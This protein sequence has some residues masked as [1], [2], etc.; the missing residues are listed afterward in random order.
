MPR[1]RIRRYLKRRLGA[2]NAIGCAMILPNRALA[3]PFSG[4]VF[5]D[6][7][8]QACMALGIVGS[9]LGAPAVPAVAQTYVP[10]VYESGLDNTAPDL[11]LPMRLSQRQLPY[12]AQLGAFW[13]YPS[14]QLDESLNDNI[15][16]T[17]TGARGDAI[18]TLSARTSLN[19]AAGINALDVQGWLADHLYA[20]HPTEDAW[21]GT[22][23]A[24]FTSDVHDDV[25]LVANG[26]IKRLVDPRTDPSGLQGLTPTTYEVYDGTAGT[27]IGHAETNLLDLRIGADRTTWDPLQGSLGPIITNDRDNTEIF[28]EAD[29]R[30][31]LAPGRDLYIKLRPNT[32]DYDLTFD[33]S[34]FQR[35]SNGVRADA[36]VDWN[37]DAALLL[38]V[39]GG[40]QRQAYNDPRFGTIGVPDARIK[41]SWWPTRLTNVT[42]NGTHE[43]YEAFFIPSPGAVRNKAVVRIDHE[44][45][46]R[47]LA[48][49][50]LSVER[51][52]LQ[53]TPTRYLAENAELSLQYLFADGFSAGIDYSFAHQTSSGVVVTTGATTFQQNIVTFTV[54]KLF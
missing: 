19:Y 2:L 23:Q 12:G 22:L 51:D 52:D 34:G 28:G 7:R 46:R 48:S 31:A 6:W 14:L 8:S 15:Y 36:G 10:G 17:P 40:Y 30:H 4:P 50:A 27:I 29:F 35:G 42:L 18:T 43:Y 20:F 3:V 44:L 54:K 38:N 9:L 47:W 16:A 1:R 24:N 32:R 49:I 39:E 21:E 53:D 37:I 33:Q 13:L 5:R 11:S 26:D 41:L 45:R 25:K